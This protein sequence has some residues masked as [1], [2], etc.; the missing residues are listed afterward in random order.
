M[1]RISIAAALALSASAAPRL[2]PCPRKYS[3][4]ETF[5]VDRYAGEWYEIVRDKYTPFELVTGC[6]IAQYGV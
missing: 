5:D 3:P 1:N 4:M 2:G 6:E